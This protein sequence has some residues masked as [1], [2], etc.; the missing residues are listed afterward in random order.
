MATE[1]HTVPTTRVGK[2]CR[3][4]TTE[5]SVVASLSFLSLGT[6]ITIKLFLTTLRG[7]RRN[8]CAV[9]RDGEAQQGLG[10]KFCES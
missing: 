2:L 5:A 6:L 1:D 4:P 8:P 9:A 3:V 7:P 10:I